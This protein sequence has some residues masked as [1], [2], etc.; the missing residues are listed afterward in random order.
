MRDKNN[1]FIKWYASPCGVLR[2]GALNDKLCLCDW[3]VPGHSDKVDRRLCRLFDAEFVEGES[4][5]TRMA[6]RQ[7]DKYF[8]GSLRQFDVPMM[9]AGTVFQKTVWNALLTIPYGTTISYAELASRIGMPKAVRA[10]ANAN[11]ANAIS[12]F[13]PCHRVIGSDHT[14]TGYAGG[15]SA[16][17]FILNLEKQ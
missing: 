16:K 1:I 5:V 8:A 7:L 4:A 13:A 12:I 2:L 14:L 11:G 6:A 9:F 10:V 15:L 17:E 3:D